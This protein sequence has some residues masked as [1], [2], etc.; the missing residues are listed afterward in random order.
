MDEFVYEPVIGEV[1]QLKC[2]GQVT[3]ETKAVQYEITLK[4]IG[5]KTDGMPYVLAEA[6][7][8]GDHRA[9]VQIKNLTVQLSGLKRERLEALWANHTTRQTKQVL[10]DNRSI[11]AFALGKPSEAFG[12]RYKMFDSERKI[13][14]LPG[15]PYKFL[16]RIISIKD[17]EPW[18]LKAGGIIEAEYDILAND[19]YFTEDN[20]PYM[21]FAILLEVALQPCGWLAAYLGSALTSETD[22]S[23][24]NLGGEATQFIKVSPEMGTLTTKVKITNVSQSGGMIIQNFDYEMH[25][26]AGIVYKGNTYFG[27]F[28]H[29]ALAEQVGF[30]DVEPY[31]AS[32][33]EQA[34]GKSFSYPPEAP[35]PADMM[36]MVDEITLYDSHGGSNDLGFIE[37][38]ANVKEEAWFFKA[39]FYED[40]V[41]PG[42]LGLESFMQL[43]KVFAWERWQ[44]EL[45]IGQFVFE[46]MALNQQHEWVYRG[47]ILPVDDKVTVQ[48]VITDIDDRS[49]T[50]KADG[51]LTVDGRI[52]YQMKDFALRIT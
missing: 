52:I 39:H 28:S 47:Q 32:Q 18:V 51:F 20:Q 44:D 17:C 6:L 41:W 40:P 13:A 36:R 26:D 8:Y 37:G 46:S 7:M 23:F 34:R 15:P 21:P 1:S 25:A 49:R 11:L 10:F 33:E 45:E 4:E 42:S 30:R 5:Y 50:L 16:D 12:D 24:R 14:R 35:M 29:E 19:W 27:F 2:R 3:E 9:I 31:K 43:L 22:I 48:A 38:T